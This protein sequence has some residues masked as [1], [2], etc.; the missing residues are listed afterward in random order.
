MKTIEGKY[1][2][3]DGLM[4]EET[5][6]IIGNKW[7][8]SNDKESENCLNMLTGQQLCNRT[9]PEKAD[10]SADLAQE[11][12]EDLSVFKVWAVE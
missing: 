11:G 9:L 1:W 6:N 7:I 5:E 3:R 12:P 4:E 10:I 2:H 8:E